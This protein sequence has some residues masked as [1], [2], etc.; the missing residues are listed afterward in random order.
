MFSQY[1]SVFMSLG[2]MGWRPNLT[3]VGVYSRLYLVTAFEVLALFEEELFAGVRTLL[4][5]E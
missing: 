5:I 4:D 1:T 2:G 3:V